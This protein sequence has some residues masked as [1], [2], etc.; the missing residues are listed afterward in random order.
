[1]IAVFLYA[2]WCRQRTAKFKSKPKIILMSAFSKGARQTMNGKSTAT[3][4][5]NYM[6]NAYRVNP[7]KPEWTIP[8]G[9][10]EDDRCGHVFVPIYSPQYEK[11]AKDEGKLRKGTVVQ[12]KAMHASPFSVRISSYAAQTVS[13]LSI[14]SP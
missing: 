10:A 7:K 3:N 4:G 2:E 8:Q 13:L 9:L 12:S 11:L 6:D 1:M 5:E 14:P